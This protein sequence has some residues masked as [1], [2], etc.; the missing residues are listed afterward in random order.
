MARTLTFTPYDTVQEFPISITRDEKTAV[1]ITT[2][3]ADLRLDISKTAGGDP[4]V[5]LRST[6]G[7]F[8]ITPAAVASLIEGALYQHNIWDLADPSDPVRLAFGT[9]KCGAS[10]APLGVTY[11]TAI[12]AG[13]LTAVVLTAAQYAALDPKDPATLYFI[14]N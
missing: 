5:E 8:A 6:G 13:G 2:G 11:P 12:L 9:L 7:A 4:L 3:S 14:V 10:I 1:E